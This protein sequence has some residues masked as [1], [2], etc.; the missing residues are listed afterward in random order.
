MLA[1]ELAG[2]IALG[3]GQPLARHVIQRPRAV[4]PQVGHQH[5]RAG[6]EGS[7]EAQVGFA[8]DAGA[9]PRH[10]IDLPGLDLIEHFSN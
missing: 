7:G 9:Y 4:W 1:N 2:T 10:D 5:I 6:Q 3:H 8:L